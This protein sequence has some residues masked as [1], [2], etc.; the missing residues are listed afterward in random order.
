MQRLHCL[1]YGLLFVAFCYGTADVEDKW[2]DNERLLKR[3]MEAA[4]KL[5][6]LSC[7]NRKSADSGDT[8]TLTKLYHS[9]DG[10][11]WFNK[12]NW[13]HGDPCKDNWYGV[14]CNSDG[15]VI[16]LDL[17]VNLLKG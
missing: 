7:S 2:R 12:T 13:L 9:T 3:N 17:Q 10:P 5:H 16:G 8:A 4:V 15:R 1:F 14:C 6:K 11:N